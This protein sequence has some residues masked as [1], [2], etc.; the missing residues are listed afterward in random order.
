MRV[1]ET[2]DAG[3]IPVRGTIYYKDS[4]K[5]SELIII[6]VEYI[7]MEIEEG[8][9]YISTK[10]CISFHLCA[11]GCGGKTFLPFDGWVH[12]FQDGKLSTSPS[13]GNFLGENPY[14]AHYY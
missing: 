3:S 13:I 4:M 6:F 11:C 1:F 10:Y 5:I 7:P 12:N 8:I 2:Q 9:I 14:H